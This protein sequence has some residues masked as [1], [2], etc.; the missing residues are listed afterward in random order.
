MRRE[1]TRHRC[2]DDHLNEYT[3]IEYQ[4]YR[5]WT[6][7]SGRSED[8]PTTKELFLSDGRSVNFVEKNTFKIVDTDQIIR[9]VD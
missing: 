5:R 4:N 1:I 8:V 6:P 9:T 3:V 7:I 2:E